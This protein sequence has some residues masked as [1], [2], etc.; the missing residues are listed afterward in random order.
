MQKNSEQAAKQQAT[1]D[2][3]KQQQQDVA[4]LQYRLQELET[5]KYNTMEQIRL[6]DAAPKNVKTGTHTGGKIDR[7]ANP[8]K[9]DL[10]VLRDHRDAVEREIKSVRKQLQQI[11]KTQ[12]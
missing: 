10:P 9:A 1:I 3:T 4:S 2:Q 7:A 12:H 11:Q 6:K 5:E 8:V